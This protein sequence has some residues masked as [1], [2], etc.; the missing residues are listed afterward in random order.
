MKRKDKFE[1]IVGR[2]INIFKGY[3]KIKGKKKRQYIFLI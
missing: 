2:I 1:E 3:K